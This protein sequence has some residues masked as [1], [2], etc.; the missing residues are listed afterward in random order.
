MTKSREEKEFEY[1]SHNV[2]F[3]ANKASEDLFR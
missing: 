3:A 1:G 2:A